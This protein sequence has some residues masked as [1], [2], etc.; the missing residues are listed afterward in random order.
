[1]LI[2]TKEEF[3]RFIQKWWQQSGIYETK[4]NARN[5]EVQK[6]STVKSFFNSI[7]RKN[8]PEG[9]LRPTEQQQSSSATS[10]TVEQFSI[11]P[12]LPSFDPWYIN[13]L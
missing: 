6:N 13:H 4:L 9:D 2:K 10:D 3:W 11:Y 1:M 5:S 12:T 7:A 8:I